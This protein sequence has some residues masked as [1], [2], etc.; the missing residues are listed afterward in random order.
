MQ[1]FKE[2]NNALEATFKFKNFVEAFGFM[3]KVALLAEKAD[4]HPDWENSYNTVKI[5][6]STHSAGQIVT[7]KD[8]Q[9]ATKIEAL[10]K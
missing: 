10:I 4:H 6:L 5:R 8:V 3:T 7:D 1:H 9:L 2:N